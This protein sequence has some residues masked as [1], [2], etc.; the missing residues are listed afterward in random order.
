MGMFSKAL[1]AVNGALGS[2]LGG[3]AANLAGSLLEGNQAQK[4][5]KVQR[6]WEETKAKNAHQWEVQDLKAAGLNPILS[7]G[8]SGA[9]MGSISAP[10]VPDYSEIADVGTRRMSAKAAQEQ[11]EIAKGMLGQHTIKTTSEVDVNTA[12]AEKTREE[13]KNTKEM[14]KNIAA[15]TIL[16]QKNAGL[17]TSQTA[18]TEIEKQNAIIDGNIKEKQNQSY[19]GEHGKA[20]V[21]QGLIEGYQNGLKFLRGSAHSARNF[22]SEAGQKAE[23]GINA[24]SDWIN[25]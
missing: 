24:W 15:D 18:R 5:A 9:A 2:P 4:A 20:I 12:T 1:G 10:Q 3:M 23:R 14:R 7:A 11:A 19:E 25:R 8:G 16:K 22:L 6:D 13:T 17:V 21:Q